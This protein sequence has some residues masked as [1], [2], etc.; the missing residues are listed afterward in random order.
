ML[1]PTKVRS[2]CIIESEMLNNVLLEM[3]V[4]RNKPHIF[5]LVLFHSPFANFTF[6]LLSHP[7]NISIDSLTADAAV[8]SESKVFFNAVSS[9]LAA[10]LHSLQYIAFQHVFVAFTLLVL[11][12]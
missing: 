3:I 12:W 10:F 4:L 2:G 1:K 8:E 11:T 7:L 9:S 5:L 6:N